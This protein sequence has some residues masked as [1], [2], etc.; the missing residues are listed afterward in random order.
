[1]ASKFTTE[2]VLSF[3]DGEHRDGL[4]EVLFDGSD[5]ELGMEDE[6]ENDSEPD[7]ELLDMIDEGCKDK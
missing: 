2:S 5:D 1:M 7:F 4:P 6:E 3:F